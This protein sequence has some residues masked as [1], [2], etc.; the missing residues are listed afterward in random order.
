MKQESNDNGIDWA[1]DEQVY[2]LVEKQF[3]DYVEN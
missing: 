2:E 1:D 3:W